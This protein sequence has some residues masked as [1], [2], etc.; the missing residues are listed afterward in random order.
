MLSFPHQNIYLFLG[1]SRIGRNVERPF[2]R[3][4]GHIEFIKFMEFYGMPRVYFLSIFTRFSGKNRTSMYISREKRD[5]YYI[6]T[7]HNDVF[8]PLQS[9]STK[10]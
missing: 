5:H 10:T 1:S 2:Y 7:R 9:F 4:G 6:Q 3:Y 8:F